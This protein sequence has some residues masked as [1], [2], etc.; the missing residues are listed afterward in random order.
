MELLQRAGWEGRLEHPGGWT[1]SLHSLLCWDCQEVQD[2]LLKGTIYHAAIIV[3]CSH[4]YPFFG[5]VG[6]NLDLA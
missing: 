2:I 1:E 6:G 4:F 3:P 5:G